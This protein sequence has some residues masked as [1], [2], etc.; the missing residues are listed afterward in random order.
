[1][2]AD[3]WWHRQNKVTGITKEEE[4][5]DIDNLRTGFTFKECG[6]TRA[7]YTYNDIN[8]YVYNDCNIPYADS[9]IILPVEKTMSCNIESVPIIDFDR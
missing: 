6:G 2:F 5:Q 9:C 7:L 4:L 3:F 1:M 8:S